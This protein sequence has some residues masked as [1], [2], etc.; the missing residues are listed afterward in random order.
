[1]EKKN[2]REFFGVKD[3]AEFCGVKPTAL[4]YHQNVGHLVPYTRIGANPMFL[5]EDVLRFRSNHYAR[6]GMTKVQIAEMYGVSRSLVEYYQE[7]GRLTPIAK[8][9]RANVYDESEVMEV[10][11]GN[12]KA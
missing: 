7:R 11:G 10:F 8:R 1:M 9:G 6:N 12:K 3:V 5:R 2:E 4:A